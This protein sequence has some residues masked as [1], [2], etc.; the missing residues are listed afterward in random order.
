M[1]CGYIDAALLIPILI[2]QVY[3]SDCYTYKYSYM[4]VSFNICLSVTIGIH[5]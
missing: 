1:P 4:Y 3:L 2:N 5:I